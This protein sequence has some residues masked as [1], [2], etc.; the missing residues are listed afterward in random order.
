MGRHILI[1]CKNVKTPS[2]LVREWKEG[3]NPRSSILLSPSSPNTTAGFQS[4]RSNVSRYSSAPST[5]SN[6]ASPRP[7]RSSVQSPQ[8]SLS[9]SGRTLGLGIQHARSNNISTQRVQS[10]P[11]V[12]SSLASDSQKEVFPATS[13]ENEFTHSFRHSNGSPGRL[14]G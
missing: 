14:E 9:S 2:D 10:D 1:S 8:L 11:Y 13:L 6:P 7:N 5:P 4:P 12:P 3:L